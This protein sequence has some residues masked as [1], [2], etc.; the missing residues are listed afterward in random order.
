MLSLSGGGSKAGSDSDDSQAGQCPGD[1]LHSADA[2]EAESGEGSADGGGQR[3]L[4]G[5]YFEKDKTGTYVY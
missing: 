4:S 5:Q 1:F 2:K 3:S